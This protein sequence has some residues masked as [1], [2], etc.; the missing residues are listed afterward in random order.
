MLHEHG[1]FAKRGF[2]NCAI[3]VEIQARPAAAVEA[4]NCS[5]DPNGVV[6]L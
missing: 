5:A 1:G 3:K 2:E 4:G 6:Q